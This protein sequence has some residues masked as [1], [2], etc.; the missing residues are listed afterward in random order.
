MGQEM[1][2]SEKKEE[3]KPKKERMRRAASESR[4]ERSSK[5]LERP[6]TQQSTTSLR[7]ESRQE[8][9]SFKVCVLNYVVRLYTINTEKE[10][11]KSKAK[12]TAQ[13]WGGCSTQTE[14]EVTW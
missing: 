3:N 1:H 8:K 12:V 11:E 7:E 14:K 6:V 10:R 4:K 2:T 9:V 5:S 13:Y